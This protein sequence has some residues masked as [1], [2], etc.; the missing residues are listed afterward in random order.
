MT[1]EA[2][3]ACPNILNKESCAKCDEVLSKYVNAFC[4]HFRNHL[5]LRASEFFK[6]TTLRLL[7]WMRDSVKFVT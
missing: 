2:P 4:G 6:D 3:L 5:G 1:C 7:S